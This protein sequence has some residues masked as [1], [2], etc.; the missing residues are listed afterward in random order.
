VTTVDHASRIA[1]NGSIDRMPPVLG[2]ASPQSAIVSADQLAPAGPERRTAEG[3]RSPRRRFS[4]RT[5]LRYLLTGGAGFIGSHL[6]DALVARGDSVVVVDDLSTGRLSN[7]EHALESGLVTFIEGS[8]LDPDIVDDA[9][10]SV[11]V[12]IHLAS[13]VGVQLVVDRPLES[14]LT[15]VR[16]ADITLASAARHQ[17]K[18][19]FAST[20]E[21]YGKNSRDGLHE[22]ADRILGSSR[23]TRWGYSLA[24]S[25]GEALA[26]NYHREHSADMVTVRLFNTVGARQRG[27]YG[28]V[29]PR[30]VRQALDGEPL[31]V[32]GNGNQT[33]CFTHVAD[34]VGALIDLCDAEPAAG[35]IY[36]IGSRTEVP[37]IELAHRVIERTGSDAAVE[38]VAYGEA[39]DDGFEEL[40]RRVPDISAIGELIGWE[41]TRSID[42][43]I[44]DV[45]RFAQTEDLATE[46]AA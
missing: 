5:T 34:V 14:L 44:E 17:R 30:F 35:Q 41:P 4:H 36:N 32:Y 28:M 1:P 24:K 38:L 2:G 13:A 31:T 6:A 45:V 27:A 39:F 42:D 15:N 11:D 21:I 16:G 20:S 40:G 10:R 18:L 37:I 19:I 8:V 9:V 46:L 29:L 23:R 7:L 3:G 22:D 26:Q 25:F 43:A 33:R 12:V